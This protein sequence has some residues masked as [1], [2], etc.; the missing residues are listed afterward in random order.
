MDI[1]DPSPISNCLVDALINLKH[2]TSYSISVV[3]PVKQT[4]Y[5]LDSNNIQLNHLGIYLG[6]SSPVEEAFS[7][8]QSAQ[9]CSK[10]ASFCAKFDYTTDALA[11][12]RGLIFLGHSLQNLT[13]LKVDCGHADNTI[14]L[15]VDIVQNLPMLE[16][17]DFVELQMDESDEQMKEYDY[18][19]YS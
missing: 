14:I 9:S 2:L 17:F 3:P 10:L 19:F 12:S 7:C 18:M 13:R 4:V 11:V 6:T 1:E 5:V 16:S 15:F 8:L